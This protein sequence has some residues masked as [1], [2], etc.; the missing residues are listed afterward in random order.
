[1]EQSKYIIHIIPHVIDLE[2]PDARKM[3]IVYVCN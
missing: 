2:Q 1:M 3:T